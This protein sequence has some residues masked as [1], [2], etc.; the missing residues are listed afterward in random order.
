MSI[1]LI[2]ISDFDKLYWQFPIRKSISEGPQ[3]G[4][5]QMP[6]CGEVLIRGL[7]RFIKGP[8]LSGAI[9][10]LHEVCQES[11]AYSN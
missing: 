1:Q 11:S 4:I 9:K 3:V 10:F 2:A 5:F 8:L 6:T 7:Q